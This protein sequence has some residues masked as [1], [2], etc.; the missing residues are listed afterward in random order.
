MVEPKNKIFWRVFFKSYHMPFFLAIRKY[1]QSGNE[2]NNTS[3]REI[4]L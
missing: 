2:E 1:I 4:G 3:F